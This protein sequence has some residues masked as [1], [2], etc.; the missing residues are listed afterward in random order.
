MNILGGIFGKGNTIEDLK[1]QDLRKEKVRLEVEEQSLAKQL[2]V[3]ESQKARAFKDAVGSKGTKVDDR[4]VA[5]RI[6]SLGA[7]QNDLERQASD[8]SQ[9]LTALDRMMRMKERQKSLEEKGVWATVSKMDIE[10]LTDTLMSTNV[11][12]TEQRELVG[13]INQTLGIDEATV[14]AEESPEIADILEQ[15]QSARESGLVD[16]E[17]ESSEKATDEKIRER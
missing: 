12:D 16:D 9:K 2:R 11:Q 17:F 5:R 15:I 1:V 7:K 13:V 14:A 8:A 4:I 6:S 10:N 3:L